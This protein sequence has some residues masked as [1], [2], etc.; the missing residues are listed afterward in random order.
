MT[1]VS[2]RK[3]L[4]DIIF[5][6][7]VKT[8]YFESKRVARNKSK[9]TVKRVPGPALAKGH[10]TCEGYCIEPTVPTPENLDHTFAKIRY[11][12]VLV[13]CTANQPES[14]IP[15]F[16]FE[17]PK[18]WTPKADWD[19]HV[20]YWGLE[21]TVTKPVDYWNDGYWGLRNLEKKFRRYMDYFRYYMDVTFPEE[22]W[23]KQLATVHLNKVLSFDNSPEVRTLLVHTIAFLIMVGEKSSKQGFY[24]VPLVWE[25][26]Y[27]NPQKVA[28]TWFDFVA[29]PRG[30]CSRTGDG[31]GCLCSSKLL[32]GST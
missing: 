5:N 1:V 18:F 13:G 12:S 23:C 28:S 15:M 27:G 9:T 8:E 10:P 30:V 3:K 24:F 21:P 11:N 2:G 16:V 22:Q 31:M 29:R 32:Y 25:S 14:G 7:G 4:T 17:K 19:G 20:R 6:R 26:N